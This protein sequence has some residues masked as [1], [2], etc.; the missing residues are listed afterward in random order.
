MPTYIALLKWTPQGLQT[1]RQSPSRLEAA[2]KGFEAA[3]AKMKDFYMVTGQYDM[4]AIIETPDDITLAKVIL[5]LGA[6]GNITTET[7]RAYT[8]D[9]Y[10]KIVGGV[11]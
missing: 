11:V 8:E 9:E 2:R 10:R 3:G 7:C 4:I 6:Q 1:I 5:S